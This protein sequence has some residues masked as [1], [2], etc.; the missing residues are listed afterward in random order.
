MGN[1]T[2]RGLCKT[3]LLRCPSTI[4]LPGVERWVCH[5][6]FLASP[7]STDRRHRH[8][9][10]VKR[11]S[12]LPL[13]THRRSATFFCE[14]L[15]L[16]HRGLRLRISD[17]QTGRVLSN[18]DKSYRSCSVASDCYSKMRMDHPRLKYAPDWFWVGLF[19]TNASNGP[20]GVT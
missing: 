17:R 12:I 8:H 18:H 11:V 4:V 5:A 19:T 10:S 14:T 9:S 6:S 1:G 3:R 15:I 20:G 7:V 13:M 2:R 16:T